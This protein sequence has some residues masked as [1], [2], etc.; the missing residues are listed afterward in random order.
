VT[1]TTPLAL[2]ALVAWWARDAAPDE[3]ARVEDHVFACDACAAR[4]AALADLAAGIAAL[5]R[6]GALG[7]V[8]T[9]ATIDRLRV[10]GVGLRTYRLGPGEHVLCTVTAADDYIV[11][12]LETDAPPDAAL[13]VDVL[14]AG[15]SLARFDGC[16]VDRAHGA[17]IVLTPAAVLR[18]L[19]E[20]DI[21]VR[22]SRDGVPL[23]DYH[24]HHAPDR[25][26]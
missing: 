10:D 5:A 17:V 8:T 9:S 20:V 12:W 22:M 2:D 14:L 16:P 6:T 18:P 1:C 23:A 13:A 21:V 3:A 19:G 26:A 7:L 24:F 15:S 25:P 11:S 4:L